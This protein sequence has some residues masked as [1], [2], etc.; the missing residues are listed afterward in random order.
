MNTKHKNGKTHLETTI[1]ESIQYY[2]WFSIYL[3]I[4]VSLII[5]FVIFCDYVHIM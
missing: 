2:S 3:F 1:M 5:I 4:F